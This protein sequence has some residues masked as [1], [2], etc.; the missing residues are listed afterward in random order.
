VED[1]GKGVYYAPVELVEAV[2]EGYNFEESVLEKTEVGKAAADIEYL[3]EDH[4]LVEFGDV[5][6]LHS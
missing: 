3:S 4:S 5:D 1:L 2:K 6:H